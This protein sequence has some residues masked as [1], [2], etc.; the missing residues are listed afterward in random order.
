[1]SESVDAPVAQTPRS[2]A[3]APSLL[4]SVLQEDVM[5]D[6]TRPYAPLTSENAALVLVDHQVGLMTGVRGLLHAAQAHCPDR[7]PGRH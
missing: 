3:P 7:Y 1:M 5:P 6:A 4:I 2:P